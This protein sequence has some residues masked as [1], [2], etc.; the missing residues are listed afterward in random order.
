MRILVTGAAGMLGRAVVKTLHAD[1]HEVVATDRI[2]FESPIAARVVIGE[3]EDRE[4]VADALDGVDRVAHVGA[5]PRPGGHPDDEVF[6]SNTHSTFLVL[7]EA[8]R[9]GIDRA[10]IASSASALGMAWAHRPVSPHYLPIDEDHPLENDEPYGLS[11]QV[12]ELIAAAVNRRWGID[13]ASLRFMFI[14]DE[15]EI[16]K[17]LD[18]YAADP[19]LARRELWC[20]VHL[21]DAARAV[22][23]ALTA[24]WSGTP[25]LNISAVDSLSPVPSEELIARELKDVPIRKALPGFT[26]FYDISRARALIGFAPTR[27]WR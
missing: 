24:D 25:V 10:V 1:G 9:A 18:M 15:P 26:S 11:K 6:G 21:E 7:N 14:G 3:L 20:W 27:T 22:A 2:P 5:I 12:G 19:D 23:L 8:G 13:V 4:V 16:Q 17:H